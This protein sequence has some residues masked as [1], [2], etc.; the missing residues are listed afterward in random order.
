[1]RKMIQKIA[2]FFKRKGYEEDPCANKIWEAVEPDATIEGDTAEPGT[3][4]VKLPADVVAQLK[5]AH[6][7]VQDFEQ[8]LKSIKPNITV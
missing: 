6:K 5:Q 2:S 3:A 4:A 1:M 7:E 8:A